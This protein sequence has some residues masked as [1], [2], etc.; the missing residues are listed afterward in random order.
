MKKD[1]IE[2]LQ[3]A[4]FIAKSILIASGC[5][6]WLLILAILSEV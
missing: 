5:I 1:I 4:W 3:I 2:G 6:F